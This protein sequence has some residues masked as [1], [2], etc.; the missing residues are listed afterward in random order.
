[1]LRRGQSGERIRPME[2]RDG[3]GAGA[4]GEFCV[5]EV[6]CGVGLD[7]RLALV[8]AGAGWMALADV[9]YGYEVAR[10][11]DGGLFPLWGMATVEERVGALLDFHCPDRLILLGDVVDGGREAP[12]GQKLLLV[13]GEAFPLLE[14]RE[15][16]IHSS[17]A[18]G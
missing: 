18:E 3:N 12:V 13:D 15:L 8:H 9:H 16:V 10:R 17:D 11:A 4:A 1:M 7:S 14:L 5:A 2:G 6:G